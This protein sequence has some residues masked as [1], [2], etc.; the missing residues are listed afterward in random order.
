[1]MARQSFGPFIRPVMN[2]AQ[3]LPSIIAGASVL[4]AL[5]F[6]MAERSQTRSLS[7]PRTRS[8]ESS[9]ASGSPGGAHAAGA[10]RVVVGLHEAAAMLEQ[11]LVAEIAGSG[12]AMRSTRSAS[13][14]V[15]NARRKKRW[16]SIMVAQ[17][18]PGPAAGCGETSGMSSGSAERSRTK[19]RDLRLHHDRGDGHAVACPRPGPGYRDRGRR[20]ARRRPG[21]VGS[22]SRVG[23]VDEGAG[24]DPG[25]EDRAR[26]QQLELQAVAEHAPAHALPVI[27]VRAVGHRHDRHLGMV[28]QVL[29]DARQVDD[30]GDAVRRAAAR[31]GRCP[32]ASAVAASPAAPAATITSPSAKRLP[33]GARRRRDR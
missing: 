24:L 29:A 28:D 18:R 11:R 7:M 5:M 10:A 30:A 27:A 6:G 19:P 20:S 23:R 1:M 17:R 33:L 4:P 25:R 16:P 26:T 13:G 12:M 21:C 8:R 2:A 15:R 32:T 31:P 22:A 9:T 14:L 3:R